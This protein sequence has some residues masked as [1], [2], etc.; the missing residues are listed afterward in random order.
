LALLTTNVS[1]V[2]WLNRATVL[3]NVV[4]VRWRKSYVD[5]VSLMR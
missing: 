2:R 5:A 3:D 1:R 4:I